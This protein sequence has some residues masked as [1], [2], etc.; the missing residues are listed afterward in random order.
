VIVH[1][2]SKTKAGGVVVYVADK[3]TTKALEKNDLDSDCKNIWL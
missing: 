2:D 3:Y 1:A